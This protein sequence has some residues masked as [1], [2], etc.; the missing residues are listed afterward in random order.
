MRSDSWLQAVAKEMNVSETAFIYKREDGFLLRWFT[1]KV[2]VDLCGHATLAS[3]HILWEKE[4]IKFNEKI[5]FHTRCGKLSARRDGEFIELNFPSEIAK[6]YQGSIDIIKAF[7]VSPLYIGKT[8]FD[9]LI[10]VDSEELVWNLKPD[11]HLLCKI[12]ARGVIVT[13]KSRSK[14]YDFISRFFAPAVGIDEDPVTGSAHCC[15][16]PY[17]KSKLNKNEFIAYQASE[18][19]G[20]VRVRVDDDRT[21]LSGQAVTISEGELVC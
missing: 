18:R 12:K 6:P 19:G 17:W 4:I 14:D 20:F 10:E 3:A 13:S 8:R 16:G 2:E 1:P 21:Y 5:V 15:L 7:N 9:F 11:F